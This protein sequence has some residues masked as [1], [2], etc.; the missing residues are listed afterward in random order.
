MS[1]FVEALLGAHRPVIAEVKVHDGDG[2]DLL[3]G[4]GVGALLDA[5]RAAGA[6]CV[7]VVTGRWFGGTPHLLR[8]V[9]AGTD[10]P[11][12]VKDFVTGQ[13]QLDRA[14]E[15]GAAAVL[16]TA[17]LLPR[18]TLGGLIE[19]CLR[20]GLTPFVEVV[21]EAEVAAVTHPAE[22]VIAVN[23]KDIRAR[24]RGAP[25][26]G[27]SLALLPVV[28]AAGTPC[29]VSASGISSPADAAALLAAG[30]RGLLVGTGLLRAGVPGAWLDALDRCRGALR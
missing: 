13:A 9:A 4:R 3:G 15:L 30:Y 19:R 5:Y 25:A 8:E 22:C 18:R 14:R 20:S 7:S 11:I 6:P 28:R 24:E 23:N 26:P 10:L 2:T 21:S 16:L 27:R 1:A 29:P 12:L 17:A